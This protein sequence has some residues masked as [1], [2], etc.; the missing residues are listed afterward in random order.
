MIRRPPRSTLFPYTTLFRSHQL[1]GRYG[2]A[3]LLPL[4]GVGEGGL[5]AVG[6]LAEAVPAHAVARVSEDGERRA[7]ALGLRQAVLSRDAAV[8]QLYVRLP[9]GALGALAG[10]D[11]CVVAGVVPLDEEAADPAVLGP[12][13]DH[14]HVRERGVADPLLLAAQD[15]AA[16]SLDGRRRQG[17]GVG[18]GLGLGEAEAA[19][20]LAAGHRR[21]I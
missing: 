15:V 14:G 6:G 19:D 11:L 1:E 5:V 17:T 7:Q 20:L 8:F 21:E 13:P 4:C 12:G 10:E 16:V 2:L 18:A 3:E 9:R